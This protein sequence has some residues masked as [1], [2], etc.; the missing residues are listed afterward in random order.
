MFGDGTHMRRRHDVATLS[1]ALLMAL[2]WEHTHCIG[3]ESTHA[4]PQC[5]HALHMAFWVYILAF[6]TRLF[7]IF[8]G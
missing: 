5:L 6:T 2:F 3:V 7:S 4:V 1:L 8:A